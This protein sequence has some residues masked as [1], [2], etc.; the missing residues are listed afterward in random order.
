MTWP[1]YDLTELWL[2]WAMIWLSYDLCYD[3]TEILLDR[4][5]T[6]LSYGLTE[7]WLWLD[8]AMTWLS[9][10]LTELLLDWAITW[11]SYDLTEL[12]LDGA[13]TWLS[14]YNWL[15]YYLT[16]LWLDW[17]I[18]LRSHSYIGS[19]STKLPLIIYLFIFIWFIWLMLYIKKS[20]K[21][22]KCH[23][24]VSSWR[25]VWCFI[26]FCSCSRPE[27]RTRKTRET[28]KIEAALFVSKRLL[29]K[30]FRLCSALL[31]AENFYSPFFQWLQW[32]MWTQN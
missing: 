1:S 12:L 29:E 4:A 32:N 26:R 27:P 10:D 31:C 5:M 17:A 20:L 30:S 28:E 16:E 21:E 9:Y 8:W 24:R 19:F 25:N 14:Y 18:E 2:D 22:N 13:M 6:W 23:F 3:L 7:L 15:S 11:L